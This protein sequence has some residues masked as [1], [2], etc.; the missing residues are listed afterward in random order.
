MFRDELSGWLHT[1]DR[2]GHENDRA[3]SCEAWTGTSGYTYDRIARGTLHSRAAC[4]SVL[5][6]LQKL[7]DGS[8]NPGRPAPA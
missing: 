2:P 6:G 8:G 5:G 3:V 4:L 1:L 7:A